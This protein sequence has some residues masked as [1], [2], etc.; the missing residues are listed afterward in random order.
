[1]RRR[2]GAAAVPARQGRADHAR[3]DGGGKVSA[4]DVPRSRSTPLRAM[5]VADVERVVAI[6]REAYAFPWTR[7]NFIDS[8]A[9]GYLAET[10][11]DGDALIGYFVAMPGVDE[12]HLLNLTVAPPS[13]GRGLGRSL[14]E[15][16]LDHCRQR[17]LAR[18]WLEVRAGNLRARR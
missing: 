15:R 2:G 7:G 3:T 5:R 13:Q 8:L 10:L 16:V 4:V 6:E 18:V 12:L 17:G 14:L 1:R 9:A 11:G